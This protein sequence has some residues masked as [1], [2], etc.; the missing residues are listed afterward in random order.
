MNIQI[1]GT[2]NYYNEEPN[3]SFIINNNILVEMPAGTLKQLIKTGKNFSNIKIIVFTQLTLESMFD[4]PF[5]LM[6]EIAN[7]RTEDLIL[8]GPQKLKNYVYKI[9]NFV[10]NE[11]ANK[12]LSKL[13]LTFLDANVIQKNEVSEDLY[14]SF[15][16]TNHPKYKK[17]YGFIIENSKT[18]ICYTGESKVSPGLTYMLKK[19]DVCIWKYKENLLGL[20]EIKT[21][22]EEYPIKYIPIGYNNIN[23]LIQIK[24]IKT[25]K[26]EEQFYI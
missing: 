13:E 12:Y 3:A 18:S 8:I 7:K 19:S 14:L 21:L 11:N 4:L 24:N 9:F 2:G 16:E 25:I 5:F 1:L 26:T 23:D 6:Y 15:I 22:S 17:N 10:L 20:K